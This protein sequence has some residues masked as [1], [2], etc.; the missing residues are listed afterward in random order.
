MTLDN[1][2]AEHLADRR[3]AVSRWKGEKEHEETGHLLFTGKR[4]Y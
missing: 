4:Q 1:R 3:S 2:A